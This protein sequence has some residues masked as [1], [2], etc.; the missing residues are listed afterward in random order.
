MELLEVLAERAPL[1]RE[2]DDGKGGKEEGGEDC[3]EDRRRGGRHGR[4]CSRVGEER[5]SEGRRGIGMDGRMTVWEGKCT[6]RLWRTVTSESS[7][8]KGGERQ[9]LWDPLLLLSEDDDDG[10]EWKMDG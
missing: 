1:R 10:D 2:V 3:V 6:A 5:R 4:V 9:N 8:D 7:T